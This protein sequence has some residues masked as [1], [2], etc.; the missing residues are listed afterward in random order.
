MPVLFPFRLFNRFRQA[1]FATRQERTVPPRL[2]VLEARVLLASYVVTNVSGDPTV[3]GSLP[4][5]VAQV[6]LQ[7]QGLNYITFD[8][9]ASDEFEFE[10]VYIIAIAQPLVLTNQVVIDGTTQP[11]YSPVQDFGGPTGTVIEI[12]GYNIYSRDPSQSAAATGEVDNVFE[13][14]S[15]PTRG[16]TSSGSTIQ[17]LTIYGYSDSGVKILN[18]SQN[19]F[20][21]NNYIGFMTFIPDGGEFVVDFNSYASSANAASIG[22]DVESSNNTIRYNTISGNG[23]GVVVGENAQSPW[24]GTAYETNSIQFNDIGTAPAGLSL[25]YSIGFRSFRL[26][27]GNSADGIQLGAGAQQNYIGPG[28][29][30]SGNQ[31]NGI[32]STAP[33]NTGNVVFANSIG[34]DVTTDVALG[35]SGYGILLA[36]GAGGNVIGGP[37]GGNVIADNAAGGIA[38]GDGTTSAAQNLVQG[39]VLGLN[40]SQ[41][42]VVGQQYLGVYLANGSTGNLVTGNVIAGNVYHGVLVG[43]ATGNTLS[44]NWIGESAYGTA[45][46]NGGYG[47]CLLAGASDNAIQGNALGVNTAGNYYGLPAA[48]LGIVPGAPYKPVY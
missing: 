12:F 46:A 30:I 24:N 20:I 48:P 45:F 11:G 4:Y 47:V 3:P 6:D 28:N 44:Q 27:F 42:A 41:T 22:V 17:G 15:N 18:G 40:A 9:P 13:L 5:A 36:G 1:R 31:S 33:S 2:E 32:E 25:P 37:L 8:I 16:T 19:D 26:Y 38:L 34:T 23:D 10:G 35:N 7:P 39:N 43:A 14:G 21:Q 29:V